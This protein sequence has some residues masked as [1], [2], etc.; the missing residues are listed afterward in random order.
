MPWKHNSPR[1]VFTSLSNSWRKPDLYLHFI[2]F[3]YILNL[4][5]L[6]CS[7]SSVTFCFHDDRAVENLLIIL[8]I[9]FNFFTSSKFSLCILIL[10]GTLVS[11]L[12]PWLCLLSIWNGSLYHR[13]FCLLACFKF[14]VQ[15]CY[16]WCLETMQC[17]DMPISQASIPIQ[18]MAL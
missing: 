15:Y 7:K 16:S 18:I 8:F 5:T 2:F 1:V 11:F 12:Y 9:S 4:S 17:N 3:Y 13:A 6:L 10:F 14:L